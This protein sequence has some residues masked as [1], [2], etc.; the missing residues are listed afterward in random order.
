LNPA[1][2]DSRYIQQGEEHVLIEVD[3]QARK[4]R[5]EHTISQTFTQRTGPRTSAIPPYEGHHDTCREH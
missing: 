5:E 3:E 2:R 4:S 1:V